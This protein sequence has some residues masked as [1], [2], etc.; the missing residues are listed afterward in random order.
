MN[1]KIYMENTVLSHNS[2]LG[3]GENSNDHLIPTTLERKLNQELEYRD[4]TYT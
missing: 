3:Q 1:Y 2:V 4:N